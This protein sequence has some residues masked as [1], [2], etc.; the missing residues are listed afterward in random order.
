MEDM[1]RNWS[2]LFNFS[3]YYNLQLDYFIIH[4]Y[5][6]YKIYMYFFININFNLRC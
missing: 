4:A 1:H 3:K 2:K 5:R 6:L